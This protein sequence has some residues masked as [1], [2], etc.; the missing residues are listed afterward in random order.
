MRSLVTGLC[1]LLAVV[2]PVQAVDYGKIDRTLKKEP[3]YPSR[4]PRYALLLFGR[5]VSLRIW[6]VLDG[7]TVYLDRNGNADLT[8]PGERFDKLSDCKDIELADTD[9]KTRYRLTGMVVLKEDNP[10][11][12]E[13][14]VG[15]EIKGP[16]CYRQY[17]SVELSLSPQKAKVAHFHGPLTAGPRTV[18][19]KL[20]SRLAMKRGDQPVDLPLV[21]GTMNAEHGC[22]VVV[23]SEHR[24]APAFSKGVC[25]VVDIEFPA[26]VPGKP[27]K[28]RYQLD[29]V[30]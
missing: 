7:D 14:N 12:R 3:A 24:N 19:W 28:R 22:W 29:Q 20:P 23:C 2:A 17:C 10:P 25:P 11:C 26:K 21:V 18:G 9:G 5:A 15:V 13:L 27:L 6:V 4:S 8:E 16:V 30:C 1:L